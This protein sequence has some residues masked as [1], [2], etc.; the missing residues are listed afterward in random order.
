MADE[1]HD[2]DFQWLLKI[3]P[4][5]FKDINLGELKLD[6]TELDAIDDLDK[7]TD[8][9]TYWMF[10]QWLDTNPNV[11]NRDVIETLRSEPF[12][13]NVVADEYIKASKNIKEGQ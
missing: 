4:D 7:E 10:E 12:G 3:K 13:K 11:T 1:R 9:K 6:T 5:L 2:T 8:F